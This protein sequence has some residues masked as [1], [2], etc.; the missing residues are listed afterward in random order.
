MPQATDD[1]FRP[2][3]NA[4]PVGRQFI[5]PLY[6]EESIFRLPLLR[7]PSCPYI[8]LPQVNTDPFEVRTAV[9]SYPQL[10]CNTLMWLIQSSS[11]GREVTSPSDKLTGST[12]PRT[13]FPATYKLPWDVTTAEWCW[14]VAT[15][16]MAF[17]SR[18]DVTF[19]SWSFCVSSWP[20]V[21]ILSSES[22][23][24]DCGPFPQEYN[25]LFVVSTTTSSASSV[26]IYSSSSTDMDNSS[27]SAKSLVVVDIV[28][29]LPLKSLPSIGDNIRRLILGWTCISKSRRLP[30]LLNPLSPSKSR[31][32]V[33]APSPPDA[34]NILEL[35]S[36]IDRFATIRLA[37]KTLERRCI[38]V[39]ILL[40]SPS[41][42]DSS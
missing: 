14:P 21:G 36:M 1:A 38:L 27:S 2:L 12:Q 19:I 34:S 30:V 6:S 37:N 10:T 39:L 13:F 5:G 42:V 3:P 26:S 31:R 16:R 4:R 7:C 28:V 33:C 20:N 8:L 22:S 24:S 41:V 23:C 32:L 9:W 29:S 17:D 35:P 15:A 18:R 25:W 40:P 11:I